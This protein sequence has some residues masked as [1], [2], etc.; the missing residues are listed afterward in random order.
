MVF[1][2]IKAVVTTNQLTAMAPGIN[3][4]LATISTRLDRGRNNILGQQRKKQKTE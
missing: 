4:A 2:A 1:D 3:T